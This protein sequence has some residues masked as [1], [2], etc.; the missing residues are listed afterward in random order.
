LNPLKL[1][2]QPGF[3]YVVP[4]NPTVSVNPDRPFVTWLNRA[5]GELFVC[6]DNTFGANVWVGQM[7]TVVPTPEDDPYA[8]DVK[9]LLPFG[10]AAAGWDDFSNNGYAG[11]PSGGAVISSFNSMGFAKPNRFSGY[12]TSGYFD[13]SSDWVTYSGLTDLDLGSNDFT[14]EVWACFTQGSTGADY[15]CICSKRYDYTSGHTFS[16]FQYRSSGLVR[17]AFGDTSNT[18]YLLD[19]TTICRWR[20]HHIAVTRTGNVFRLFIDGIVEAEL[21]AA[22]ALQ[23]CSTP[24]RVSAYN[25]TPGSSS[26]YQGFIQD[27]RL[28]LNRSRYSSNFIPPPRLATL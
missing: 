13:G 4:A 21:T 27:L 20:F 17:F 1:I 6:R 5:T 18:N 7:G 26:Y 11:T 19:S 22:I 28:T 10:T 16:L 14:L 25:N 8:N 24:F 9:I 12:N 3:D 23:T 2:T 15:P